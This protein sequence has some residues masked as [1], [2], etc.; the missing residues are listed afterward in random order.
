MIN[1]TIIF[2]CNFFS[3]FSMNWIENILEFNFR[4][5]MS[6]NF[7]TRK[8]LQASRKT[9]IKY[10]KK[11]TS[12]LQ[13]KSEKTLSEANLEAHSGFESIANAGQVQAQCAALKR[14]K[15]VMN[16]D[17]CVEESWIEKIQV[18]TMSLG[19]NLETEKVVWK[20]VIGE[21]LE[22]RSRV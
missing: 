10:C 15:G 2:I 11:K 18:H 14:E 8:V 20:S 5:V 16:W 4:L 21:S 12:V 7:L 22:V 6:F 3:Q 9:R 1:A 17:K 19:L 13:I